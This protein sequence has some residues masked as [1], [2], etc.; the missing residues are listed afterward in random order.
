MRKKLVLTAAVWTAVIFFLF[1]FFGRSSAKSEP[2]N[3]YFP[4][5]RIEINIE[6]DGSFIVDEYRTYD[7]EG[8]FSGISLWIPLYTNRQGYRYDVKIDD[9]K[10]LDEQ[11]LP[12]RIDLSRASGK[13][14]AKWYYRASNQ[15][16]TLV[17]V[18][19]K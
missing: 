15:L 16:R 14:T 3:Y 11:G 19:I 8:S 5:I 9:F 13:L 6:R 7:F 1:F 4:E 17:K 18:P 12:L 2:K 10:V